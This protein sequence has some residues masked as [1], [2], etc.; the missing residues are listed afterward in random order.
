MTEIILAVITVVGVI[1]AGA[2]KDI[3]QLLRSRKVGVTNPDAQAQA[4]PAKHEPTPAD[5]WER[6]IRK[7]E[8]RSARLEK[9]LDRMEEWNA[10]QGDHID[11]LENHIWTGKPPPP[12]PRPRYIPYTPSPSEEDE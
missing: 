8:R 11:L 2:G 7:V 6:L 10:E 5:G 9:R 3:I 1:G 12:P 4:P